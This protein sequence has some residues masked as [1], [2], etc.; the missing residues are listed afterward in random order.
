MIDVLFLAHHR[1]EFTRA[2]LR[3]LLRNTP[4]EAVNRLHIY[5]DGVD[6]P[7]FGPRFWSFV[8]ETGLKVDLVTAHH[9]GPVAIMAAFLDRAER[10]GDSQEIFAKIDNDVILPP[11][12][13]TTTEYIM[14]LCPEL[15]L[16]GIEPPA[17]RTPSRENG[18]RMDE[19][20]FTGP[21]VRNPGCPDVGYG[22][23]PSIGGIG[24]MRRSAWK[25][26]GEMAPHGFRGV[27][28]FTTWQ[29]A[30][31]EVRK[32][33]CVPP[34]KAFLLDRLPIDPWKS[35]SERY[36]AEGVQRPWTN[37]DPQDSRLWDWWTHDGMERREI[38]A[39][40]NS[41]DGTQDVSLEC[42]HSA[43]QMIPIPALVKRMPCAQ[44]VN[45]FVDD[46]RK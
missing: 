1:R 28:G 7:D 15:D 18:R 12:W 35:L 31:R 30:H 19:P 43:V 24:L 34:L 45:D 27:G 39:R 16:L 14:K 11:G 10:M 21:I 33:W 26:R 9:G 3:T 40:L 5:T 32:G 23:T 22:V 36:I 6:G 46:S 42:G 37:Y 20:E 38:S 25:G 8:R 4:L 17:S 29:L 41:S 2:S 13:L 44:C